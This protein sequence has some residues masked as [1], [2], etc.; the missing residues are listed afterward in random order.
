MK[1]KKKHE[2]NKSKK[3]LH[4]MLINLDL[5]PVTYFLGIQRDWTVVKLH[6]RQR[7]YETHI[8]AVLTLTNLLD[9]NM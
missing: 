6:R 2:L 4:S 1:R 3:L 7:D 9:L 5:Y 8:L